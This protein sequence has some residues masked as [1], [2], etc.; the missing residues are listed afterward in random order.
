MEYRKK[1]VNV[2]TAQMAKKLLKMGYCIVDL[3][4]NKQDSKRTVFVFENAN[5]IEDEIKN[6]VKQRNGNQ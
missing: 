5:G 4:P 1:Y 6:I 2:F 3:K